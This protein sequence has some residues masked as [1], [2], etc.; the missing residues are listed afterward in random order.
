[1]HPREFKDQS[2]ADWARIG[3]SLA[4]PETAEDGYV[5]SECSHRATSQAGQVQ[6]LVT[7]TTNN[8]QNRASG[9]PVIG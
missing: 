6:G 2:I 5:P 8:L 3:A 4:H 7:P 1:M 9:G